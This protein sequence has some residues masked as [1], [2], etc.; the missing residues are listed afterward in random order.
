LSRSF[1]LLAFACIIILL[2]G[3]V[4]A[5]DDIVTGKFVV[6]FTAAGQKDWVVNALENNVYKD[7]SGY[8]RVIPFKKLAQEQDCFKPRM[9]CILA[10]YKKQ[11]VDALMLAVVDVSGIDYEVY[12]VQNESLVKTG[13]IPI[14]QGS[15]LLKLR[16]GAFEAFKPFLEKGGILEN[17]QYKTDSVSVEFGQQQH[18]FNDTRIRLLIFLAILSVFPYFLS[19]V[20]KPLRH[21][22]RSRIVLR[23]FYPFVIGCLSLIAYQYQLETSAAGTVFDVILKVSDGYHWIITGLGGA[24]WGYFFI[25]NYKIVVP[26]LQGL[27]RIKPKNILPV[28]QSCLYTLLVK[29][30]FL[31]LFYAG[32]FYGV[33]QVGTLFS[34]NQ[35]VILLLLI[36]LSGLY[37]LYWAGLILDV[38]SMSLDVRLAE[39]KPDYSNVWNE[40]VRKYFIAH[41]KRNGVSLSRKLVDDVVFLAGQHRGVIFY[42]GGFSRPRIAIEK[43]LIKFALG[44]IDDF[45][46][47]ETSV[48]VKKSFGTIVRQESLLQLV[49]NLAPQTQT[50]KRQTPRADRKREKAFQSVRYFFE[51][52]V[53]REIEGRLERGA[54]ARTQGLRNSANVLEGVVLPQLAGKDQFPSLMSDNRDE[55]EIV[56]QLLI[57]NSFKHDRYDIEAEVDDSSEHDRDFLFGTLLH[58]FGGLLRRDD[59]FS[60]LYFYFRYK[61]GVQRKPYNF[62][63]SK[64]FAI[65]ADAFVVLNFG[66]N[67]LMQHLYYQVT[68][69]DAPLTKKGAD[70]DI[71]KSQDEILT[72]TK[73]LVAERKAKVIQTDELERLVWLSRF[74]QDAIES[75]EE[76]TRAQRLVRWAV[77]LGVLYVVSVVLLNAYNYHPI[78]QQIIEQERQEIAKAIKGTSD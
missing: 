8:E 12:D 17:R 27:E 1:L 23:W 47:Q 55:M 38:F 43:D 42:G 35:E 67:H 41:L 4:V 29:S 51:R 25:I 68:K 75:R 33:Y 71:L 49:A 62:L 14:G 59:V 15:S 77:S 5:E 63:L 16:M 66:L 64:Y 57:D 58:K 28:L 56:A 46:P 9:P 26:H 65:V 78:Y 2:N 52:T 70:S 76:N 37:V 10:L 13:S 60:T 48:Y 18:Q 30:A 31:L 44:D 22:E 53:E 50:R 6:S 34:L 3:R 20:G 40:K 7:L 36:P 21:P 73:K 45:N 69:N 32:F 39:G 24:V 74:C 61:K 54:G 19:F 72:Q 11:Q